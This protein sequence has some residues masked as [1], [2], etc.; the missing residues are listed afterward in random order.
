MELRNSG[1]DRAV[2]FLNG[3][4]GTWNEVAF[5]GPLD[6]DVL[7]YR[8]GGQTPLL[9]VLS[10]GLYPQASFLARKGA[11]LTVEDNQGNGVVFRLLKDDT[12]DARAFF[13]RFISKHPQPM[14]CCAGVFDRLWDMALQGRDRLDSAASWI[15]R[16]L[17]AR[18]Q[19]PE[20][21]QGN[22]TVIWV[23]EQVARAMSE[24]PWDGERQK[25]EAQSWERILELC[26]PRIDLGAVDL[27]GWKV[28]DVLERRVTGVPQHVRE[29]LTGLV[30][31][32]REKMELATATPAVE[33]D[34]NP[35]RL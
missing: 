35:R 25:R 8:H 18:V 15:E 7:E 28:E 5:R 6:Q 31:S 17:D 1:A 29:R 2:R 23:V 12:F 34:S 9:F 4:T 10:L 32:M 24:P 11:D 16:L 26:L 33:T 3:L 22:P 13:D 19:L 30:V 27:R 14:A 20:T 21:V